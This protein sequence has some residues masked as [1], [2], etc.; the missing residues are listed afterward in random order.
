M[1]SNY[2]EG[3]TPLDSIETDGLLLTHIT[4]PQEL[5]RWEYE[6][7][8]RAE[9]WAFGRN[10]KKILCQAFICQLHKKMFEDVWRWAG[11]FR[12]SMKNIG[13]DASIIANEIGLLCENCKYW[14]DNQTFSAD[15]IGARFHHRL[16][17][18][19]PFANGSGRHSR[20]MTDIVLTQLL[21]RPVFTWGRG[22]L[23]SQ[24]DTRKNYIKALK[25]ADN[26]DLTLLLEFVRS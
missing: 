5:N 8:L 17:W 18:I 2:P 6:N 1:N 21:E 19:H 15:E 22:D 23:V 25:S 13:V 10:H 20:L 3:A 14:I 26:S 24:G 12:K 7:I 4:T 11:Q 16:V 9:S